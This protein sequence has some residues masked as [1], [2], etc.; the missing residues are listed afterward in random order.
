MGCANLKVMPYGNPGFCP[1]KKNPV[2]TKEL[3]TKMTDNVK[4]RDHQAIP[5]KRDLSYEL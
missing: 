1:L 4:V 3:K 5:M 2:R